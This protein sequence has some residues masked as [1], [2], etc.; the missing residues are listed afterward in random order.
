ML[1][2]PTIE[3]LRALRLAVMADAWIEQNKEAKV[4][5]LTFDERF[6]L[7]VDAEYLARDNRRLGRL[8]K[9]AQLRIPGACIEDVEVSAERGL[10]RAMV[11]QLA[12]C[13]WVAE[14]LNV[15]LSGPTG[16]GKSYV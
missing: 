4:S 6:G 15:L 10:D 7:L 11:R 1:N 3:K 12:S 14:H 5:S 8:L 16:V 2:E 9:D 13:T